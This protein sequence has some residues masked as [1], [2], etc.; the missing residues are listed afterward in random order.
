MNAIAV[1]D[2]RKVYRSGQASPVRAL[3]GVSFEV[4]KGHIFGLLGPNGA[5]KS[6]LVKILGTITSPTQ[7]HAMVMGYDVARHAI[8]ARR[9]MAV[10]LQQ[11]AAE[12]LLTVDDN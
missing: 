12:T 10:V 8:E 5:G 7:G 2:V 1:K 9:Q 11:T 4:P 6:T 3:D